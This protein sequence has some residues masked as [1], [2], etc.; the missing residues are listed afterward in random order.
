MMVGVVY[1]EEYK[2]GLCDFCEKRKQGGRRGR[3]KWEC[4]GG[5]CCHDTL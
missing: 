1:E 4:D 5:R 3:G 2:L